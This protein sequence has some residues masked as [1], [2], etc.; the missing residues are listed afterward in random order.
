MAEAYAVAVAPH[1]NNSTTVG[2]AAS[3][4]V[5]AVMPNFL[6]FEHFAGWDK[7]SKEL[8]PN[9][10][11]QE[12]GYLPLPTTPGIG[13][14]LDEAALAKYPYSG[15]RRRTLMGPEDERP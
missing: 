2:L 5:A 12:G 15:P 8:S 13:I 6:I 7:Y 14:D 3:L 10:I 1:G 11:F 4:Q 9:P